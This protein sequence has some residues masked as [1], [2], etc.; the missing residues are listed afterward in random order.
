M[1]H[2]YQSMT[3]QDF[4]HFGV[5]IIAYVKPIE[6]DGMRLFELYSADGICLGTED[7][8]MGATRAAHERNLLP[9]VVH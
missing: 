3:M 8:E 2:T 1:T 4:A 6:H 5:P 9:V 7:T